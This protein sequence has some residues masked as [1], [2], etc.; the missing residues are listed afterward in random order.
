MK[1]KEK[2][3]TVANRVRREVYPNPEHRFSNANIEMPFRE[4]EPD[5]LPLYKAPPRAP[6]VV[7]E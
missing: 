7:A 1:E 5:F 6:N 3:H 4:S 2:G